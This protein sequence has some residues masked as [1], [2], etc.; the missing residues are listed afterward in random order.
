MVTL[1]KEDVIRV[2]SND[3]QLLHEARFGNFGSMKHIDFYD[4]GRGILFASDHRVLLIRRDLSISCDMDSVDRRFGQR[5]YIQKTGDRALSVNPDLTAILDLGPASV[6]HRE[7]VLTRWKHLQDSE[8][9]EPLEE[10]VRTESPWAWFPDVQSVVELGNQKL[11]ALVIT[12]Q[13]LEKHLTFLREWPRTPASSSGLARNALLLARKGGE[14]SVL[15]QIWAALEDVSH[16]GKI[17]EEVVDEILHVVTRRG[18]LLEHAEVLEKPYVTTRGQAETLSR[19]VAAVV[20]K[21]CGLDEAEPEIAYRFLSRLPD[22]DRESQ[23]AVMNRALVKEKE[24]R[25]AGVDSMSDDELESMLMASYE[26]AQEDFDASRLAGL[27][28]EIGTM[29]QATARTIE[30]ARGELD[31]ETIADLEEAIAAA[32][33]AAKTDDLAAV[34]RTRDELER[35]TLPLAAV[36]MDSVAKKALSGKSLDDV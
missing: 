26:H 35:A 12:R 2:W 19:S 18:D 27:K 4:R 34:Q 10:F 15:E 33:A 22:A 9:I 31:L 3:G 13:S 21:T 14:R 5:I 6:D 8:A 1:D 36:L 30:A 20:R 23:L 16:I 11:I 17:C 25:L 28:T 24:K 32:E 7:R 29:V